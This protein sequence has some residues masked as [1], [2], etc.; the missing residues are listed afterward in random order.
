MEVS[1]LPSPHVLLNCER[2]TVIFIFRLWFLHEQNYSFIIQEEWKKNTFWDWQKLQ[3]LLQLFLNFKRCSVLIRIQWNLDFVFLNLC[4]PW[5]CAHLCQ[6]HQNFHR[7]V[8]YFPGIHIVPSTQFCDYTFNLSINWPFAVILSTF[9]WKSEKK[10]D[11]R[12]WFPI[13][14]YSAAS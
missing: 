6:C 10:K 2:L 14:Y 5:F 8:M 9:N 13:I 7:T 11:F 1:G 4:F 3:V 12:F